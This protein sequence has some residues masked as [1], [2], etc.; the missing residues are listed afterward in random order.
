LCRARLGYPGVTVLDNVNFVVARGDVVAVLGG[1]GSGKTTLLQTIVGLVK[2]LAGEVTLLGKSISK[3][4]GTEEAR[5]F[6]RVGVVFQQNALFS[7]MTVA[8]NL[9]VL[10]RQLT[11][12][13]EP[14][15]RELVSLRLE[16]VGLHGLE[17]RR[18]DSLSG[19]Q[20]K[21]VAFARAIMLEPEVLFFD[22]PTA[23]LDPLASTKVVELIRKLRD[24]IGATLIIITHDI[25]LIRAIVNRVVIVGVG[26]IHADGRLEELLHS[27]DPIVLGLLRA[28]A[29][30]ALQ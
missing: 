4:H 30:E 14:V 27:Q 19:G 6:L 29:R 24:D 13:P 22:E 5:L 11:N 3:I 15:I 1:S 17:S 21:R 23:G 26:E 25:E 9:A 28:G 18:P 10:A 7:D 16:A 2:P 20:R 8:D 12:V